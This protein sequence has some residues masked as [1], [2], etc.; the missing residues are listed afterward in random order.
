MLVSMWGKQIPYNTAQRRSGILQRLSVC[1]SS[2]QVIPLLDRIPQE[3]TL[4]LYT[5]RD[6]FTAIL[7]KKQ[8]TGDK[9]KCPS[10]VEQINILY[11]FKH[12]TNIYINIVKITWMIFTTLNLKN[13]VKTTFNVSL[14]H[15][16]KKYL[17]LN[18]VSFGDI[19]LGNKIIKQSKRRE[20]H[21]IQ[22]Y[23]YQRLRRRVK[24]LGRGTQ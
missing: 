16:V 1:V 20:K 19:Q 17:K 3:N 10:T 2:E 12:V 21:K 15:R 4:T 5:P 23:S 14:L 11:S 24:C 6:I 8:K 13:V 7:F 22:Y 18:N 9:T